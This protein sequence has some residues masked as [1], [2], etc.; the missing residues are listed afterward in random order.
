MNKSKRSI[1]SGIGWMIFLSIILFWL[2]LGPFIAGF[3][4][5]RKSGSLKN[6]LLAAIF[7]SL[8]LGLIV[9]LI[10]SLVSPSFGLFLGSAVFVV[11]ILQSFSLIFGAFLGGLTV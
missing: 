4:G 8:I 5:G 11:V 2:P 6:S 1:G 7:P 3:I 9:G 10:F